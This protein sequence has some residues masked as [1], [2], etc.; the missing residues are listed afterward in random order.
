MSDHRTNLDVE[1]VLSSIR[2]LV[3]QD[4]RAAASPSASAG[5][6]KL[7]LTPALRVNDAGQIGPGADALDA[8]DEADRVQDTATLEKTI[9]ELEAAVAKVE[10]EFEA[11]RGESGAEEN[12]PAEFEQSFELEASSDDGD[13]GPLQDAEASELAGSEETDAVSMHAAEP[14]QDDDAEALADEAKAAAVDI[15]DAILIDDAEAGDEAA[16]AQEEG[17]AGDAAANAGPVE[18]AAEDA[19]QVADDEEARGTSADHDDRWEESGSTTV[20]LDGGE[21][22]DDGV[23]AEPVEDE[24]ARFQPGFAQNMSVMEPGEID[25]DLLR[26]MVAALVREELQGALGERLTDRLRKLVR[27]EVQLALGRRDRD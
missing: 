7:V 3:S 5:M 22:I 8:A 15:E 23:E 10:A 14:G 21:G 19:V 1:D 6:D 2:R 13:E 9:V 26:T 20:G 12:A 27:R 16:V 24:A 25:D 18:A 4:T 11:D 17:A